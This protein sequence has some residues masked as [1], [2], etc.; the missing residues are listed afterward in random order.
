MK[1]LTEVVF[2]LDRSGSMTGLEKDTIGGFN[3]LIAQQ[4]KEEGEAFVSV[5][6]FDD[7]TEVLYDRVP[8][9]DVK[10]MTDREYYAR[11]CTALLDA[12]G[13]AIRHVGRVQKELSKDA[14]PDKTLFV[15]TTDG[16]ENSS[17]LYTYAK[18]KEMIEKKQK[19]H[20]WEFLFL[21]ANI[22]A[23]K[24]AESFG[25]DRS[26]ASNY[27]ADQKGI[28]NNYEVLS[29]TITNYRACG[30]IDQKWKKEIEKD[31]KKRK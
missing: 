5:V 21:G 27:H 11:G 20:G 3:S 7:R 28:G 18:V 14:R 15:I 4:K 2:I 8:V 29:K 25:I 12:V 22:D 13:L 19:K 6:L 31:Y 23:A 16:M 1:N 24:E 26:H 9:K 30:A 17:R 10:K